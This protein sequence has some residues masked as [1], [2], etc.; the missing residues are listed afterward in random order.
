MKVFK[1]QVP[2]RKYDHPDEDLYDDS[3]LKLNMISVNQRLTNALKG[4]KTL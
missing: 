3:G 1:L 4:E 2:V